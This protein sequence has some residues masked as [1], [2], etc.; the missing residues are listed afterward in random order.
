MK[1]KTNLFEENINVLL[2]KKKNFA[3]KAFEGVG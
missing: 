2:E 3:I 1:K